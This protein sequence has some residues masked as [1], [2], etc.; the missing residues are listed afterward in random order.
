MTLHDHAPTM[1]PLDDTPHT[2]AQILYLEMRK[3]LIPLNSRLLKKDGI[4]HPLTAARAMGFS[5]NGKTIVLESELDGA[6]LS[7]YSIYYHVTKRTR[8]FQRVLAHDDSLTEREREMLAAHEK[9]FNSLWEITAT[10]PDRWELDI[11]DLLGERGQHTIIDER[12]SQSLFPGCW[13]HARLIPFDGFTCT[14]GAALP[15]YCPGNFGGNFGGKL[16]GK[17][18]DEAVKKAIL[19]RCRGALQNPK[20]HALFGAARR[21]HYEFGPELI[22]LNPRVP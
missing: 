5:I 2:A 10:R 9:S 4:V 11:R 12:M 3:V 1:N 16:G 22:Y 17:L 14:S 19:R 21:L 6:L 18:D 20:G 13:I 15:V 8:L 7:E